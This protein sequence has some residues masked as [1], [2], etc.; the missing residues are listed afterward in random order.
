MDTEGRERVTIERAIALA[1]GINASFSLAECT[2]GYSHT[3]RQL[4]RD[5]RRIAYLSRRG[6]LRCY[7]GAS[8]GDIAF[9]LNV[10]RELLR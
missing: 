5:G 3:S 6:N 7:S 1:I 2:W 8:D 4:F 10:N 9:S